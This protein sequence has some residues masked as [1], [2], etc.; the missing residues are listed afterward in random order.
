[1]KI[2][3]QGARKRRTVKTY[4]D[5]NVSVVTWE[6]DENTLVLHT[7]DNSSLYYPDQRHFNCDV[8]ISLSELQ[9]ILNEADSANLLTTF[10]FSKRE[11]KQKG[12]HQQTTEKIVKFA[13][14]TRPRCLAL[15]SLSIC[16]VVVLL[17][18]CGF[19]TTNNS[20]SPPDASVLPVK[21]AIESDPPVRLGSDTTMDTWELPHA[22]LILLRN[23]TVN[24]LF[25]VQALV[26]RALPVN[27]GQ[28]AQTKNLS[29]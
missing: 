4:V 1:M 16:F 9:L 2:L 11:K 5:Q 8:H 23:T 26:L 22:L 20:Y 24:S 15:R 19:L 27:P 10:V 25:R 28:Y 21:I 17:T 6:K 29:K 7:F 14:I 18:S 3:E 12:L 13:L